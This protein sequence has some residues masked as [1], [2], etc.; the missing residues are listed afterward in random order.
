VKRWFTIIS[1]FAIVHLAALAAATGYA[2]ARGWLTGERI[3]AAAAA[4]RGEQ[5]AEPAPTTQ[6]AAEPEK[7]KS[8]GERIRR[9]AEAD[10]KLRIELARRE[11]EIQDNWRLLE[12]QQ[13][14]FVRDKEAFEEA[15]KRWAAEQEKRLQTAG[16][17][18]AKKELEIVSGLKPEEAKQ[19]LRLKSDADAVRALMAM[20]VRKARKIVS[21]C[22]TDEER[23]WI[24]RILGQ[25]H[26]HDAAQ[27]EALGAGS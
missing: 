9:N 12:T 25:L 26:E 7:P 22:K 13:L 19:Q 5:A 18:G 23:L 20:D 27:A 2:G 11:R 21:A 6:A 10:E 15:K 14:A 24:G 4:V 1:M 8:S 17:S 16:D 3:R